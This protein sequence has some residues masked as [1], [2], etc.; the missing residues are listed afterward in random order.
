MNTR[1]KVKL[2]ADASTAATLRRLVS[3]ISDASINLDDDEVKACAWLMEMSREISI[4]S[5]RT[6]RLEPRSHE[7]VLA[8]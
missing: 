5:S 1:V 6:L 2:A 7:M 8:R 4:A 3:K